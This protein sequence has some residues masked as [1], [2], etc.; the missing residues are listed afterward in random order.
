[1]FLSKN[2]DIFD[3]TE[4]DKII[5]NLDREAE[6][7]GLLFDPSLIHLIPWDTDTYWTRDYA[8]WWIK[9]V[10]TG[11]YSI[12]KHIYTSLGGVL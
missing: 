7:K 9:D 10:K 11:H 8:P 6:Q 5:A 12:S 2:K 3:E 4:C 1:M